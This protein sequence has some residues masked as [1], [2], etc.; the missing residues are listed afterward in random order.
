MQVKLHL[1]I[2]AVMMSWSIKSMADIESGNQT[3]YL[4]MHTTN[5]FAYCRS[6]GFVSLS[7][8]APQVR[9]SPQNITLT[10]VKINDGSVKLTWTSTLAGAT[11]E[12]YRDDGTMLELITTTTNLEYEDLVT[13]CDP[14]TYS[15][16]IESGAE[17]SNT[18]SIELVNFRPEDPEMILVTVNDDGLL[19]IHWEP[20]EESDVDDYYIERKL[21]GTWQ[22]YTTI[23]ST[24]GI[25]IDDA[26]LP[27]YIDPCENSVELA[28]RSVDDCGA[29]S[30]GDV[31]YLNPL[32]TIVLSGETQTNCGRKAKLSWSAY[33][34]MRPQVV[35]Y[36][37]E[38]SVDG[39]PFQVID[40]LTVTDVS[41]Q[42]YEYTDEE[43]LPSG[44]E[45][46]YRVAATNG[47]D[48]TALKS[49]SCIIPLQ[50]DA[51][52][53]IYFDIENVSVTTGNAIEITA[54]TDPA[55]LPE[56]I[57]IYRKDGSDFELIQ[58]LDWNPSGVITFIDENAQPDS[59]TY[60]YEARLLDACKNVIATSESFNSIFLEVFIQD[61]EVLLGWNQ[62]EGWDSEFIGYK[63]YRYHDGVLMD[64]YPQ[65]INTNS[66]RETT[67]EGNF[68][69]ITYRVAAEKTDGTLSWSNEV[70]LPR[71]ARVE[72]PNAF[73]PGSV[74]DKFK[75]LIA[76]IDPTTY[77]LLIFN[78]YGQ[79]IFETNVPEQ[80]W[81]GSYNGKIQQGVYVYQISFRDQVGSLTTK[82]GVVLLLQ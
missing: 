69:N 44:K 3:T 71:E 82:R 16:H 8:N 28:I 37:I 41:M 75:P 59:Q 11:Y 74:N 77:A 67:P 18:Q 81:D 39:G 9:Q 63:V 78:R 65:D 21:S 73:R 30:P 40:D 68:I 58:T 49:Y 1:F 17:S 60:E 52:D 7:E 24:T 27:G 5:L 51:E 80:P 56:T 32:K 34:G 19:E 48:A 79:V 61:E 72:I 15:Y 10:L 20:S 29:D 33:V 76:N 23:T 38:K 43:F 57:E 2:L 14:I 46:R 45:V 70:I 47:N 55:G 42:N 54:N 53:V 4:Q 22:I 64:G 35:K 25:F 13:N 50:S 31:N 66:F 6:D 12:V 26:T 36:L 62:H